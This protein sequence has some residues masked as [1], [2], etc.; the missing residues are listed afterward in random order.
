MVE[1]M[2]DGL[3]RT[4]RNG[5]I[6]YANDKYAAMTG[7]P[8]EDLIGTS[9]LNYHDERSK[10]LIT[11]NIEKRKQGF[12][13]TYEITFLRKDGSQIPAIISAAP[14]FDANG[15]FDGVHSVLT[16]IGD[17]KRAE[18]ALRESEK[19][20]RTIVETAVEG[21][22]TIDINGRTTYVNQQ[23]AGMLGYTAEEM[24]GRSFL[25]FTN[26][27][28]RQIARK[29]WGKH[30]GPVKE[31][32]DFMFLRKDGTVLWGIVSTNPLY[33]VHNNFN[34]SFAMITDI[35]E[36]K[37]AENALKTS[38]EQYR[39]IIETANEGVWSRDIEYRTT[40]V[41]QRW[42]EMLGYSVE[43]MLGS[44]IR[45]FMF[46]PD[47]VE[48][49]NRQQRRKLGEKATYELRFKCKDGSIIWALISAS[50]V[51]DEDGTFQGSFA[52]LT[53]IT[54]QKRAQQALKESEQK[55]RAVVDNIQVGISLLNRHMEIVAAN[56]AV[57]KYFPNLKPGSRQLC[58]EQYNNP[59]QLER[60]SDCPC[61][62]TFQDGH[63]H[64]A[65]IETAAGDQTLYFHI[66]SSPILDP[67]GRV[68]YVIELAQDITNQKRAEEERRILEEQLRQSQKME[69][70]GTLASGIAHY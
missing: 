15:N 30:R 65:T 29:L 5:L 31:Q 25:E 38:E 54:E 41:N 61:V 66:V 22:W 33:D 67:E 45:S 70:I 47:I 44:D 57:L 19:R 12:T 23:M 1:L 56:K 18:R 17:L 26:D 62:L 68:E 39:R 10:A 64:K 48:Y 20:N 7:L 28:W 13:N 60:C 46:E 51:V 55:Y 4:D 40:F 11:A 43:E 58:Y 3:C 16:D 59:P 50:P 49:T 9:P 32:H 24:L 14:V 52:M 42:A 2:N 63:V 34:G 27:E 8:V 6:T 69:S 53:D 37:L 36:R 35:T 21:I